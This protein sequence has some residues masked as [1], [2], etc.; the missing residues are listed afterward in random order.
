MGSIF[1]KKPLKEP[2]Y[3]LINYLKSKKITD[4]NDIVEI[5]DNFYQL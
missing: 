1:T 2:N 3:E 4:I 5:L